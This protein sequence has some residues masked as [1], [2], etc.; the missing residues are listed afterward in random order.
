MSFF[1]NIFF[2]VPFIVINTNR[3]PSRAGIGRR[4]NTHRFIDIIAAIIIINLIHPH[5][6]PLI[7]S[8]I[9]IGPLTCSTASLRSTGVSGNISFLKSEPMA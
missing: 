7:K 3:P 4:L 1:Q 8:T 5:S 2:I 9:P 6:E